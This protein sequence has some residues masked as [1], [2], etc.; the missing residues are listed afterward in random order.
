V[1][2]KSIAAIS[3]LAG[4]TL[5]FAAER[6]VVKEVKTDGT[7]QIGWCCG[8]KIAGVNIPG[9]RVRDGWFEYFSTESVDALKEMVE[10]REI[11]VDYVPGGWFGDR[12]RAYVYVDTIFVNA[13]L[14]REGYA[15][16]DK[17]TDHRLAG[18]FADY[19]LSAKTGRKG[20]WINPFSGAET[21]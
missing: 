20:L 18:E 11:T 9:S 7:L 6:A 14:L 3:V 1:N 19:E 2:A 12:G 10:G 21:R 17:K 8:I 5:L 15:R 4:I 13:Y 16:W